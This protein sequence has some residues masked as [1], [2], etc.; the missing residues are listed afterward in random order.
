MNFQEILDR[1]GDFPAMKGITAPTDAQKAAMPAILAGQD[2][3]MQSPTGTG[4]TLAYLLPV[5]ARINPEIKGV[6]GIVVAPTY[7]LASQIA[8]VA[9]GLTD[10][11]DD[12]ALLIG[13][14]A[15]QRQEKAI[16]AKPRLVVGTLGRIVEFIMEKKLS[17][18][19]VKTLVFDEADRLFLPPNMDNIEYLCTAPLK[20]RQIVLVSATM[21]KKTQDLSAAY[22]TAPEFI[23][24]GGQ[25]P[26]NIKHFY[27][28]SEARKKTEKLRS[29]IHS[30]NIQKALI[31]VN[32]PYQIEKTVDRLKHHGIP[33]KALHAGQHSDKIARKAAMDALRQ[34]K[35]KALV[36]SDAGSRGLDVAGLTH[37][38]N[39]DIAARDKDYLHRAGRTGRAG[40]DGICISIVTQGELET[41]K[42]MAQK[43]KI[44][45]NAL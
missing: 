19:H 17:A 2:V 8:Q 13:G 27:A 33:A 36:S 44:E 10:R 11:S 21:P 30:A 43:L 35:I 14:A 23:S 7:E 42:K 1:F 45:L 22:M 29:I 40:A 38:I 6:Q 37:I 31:F 9:K 28:L 24:T 15:K 16:K 25:I 32:M 20:S 3:L 12:V 39:L 4:K 34:G 5:F 41:L 26:K 18:H